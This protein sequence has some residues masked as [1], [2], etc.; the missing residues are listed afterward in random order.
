[1]WKRKAACCT[2]SM[3]CVNEVVGV[4]A[5]R[6][7]LEREQLLVWVSGIVGEL[8]RRLDQLVGSVLA[9]NPVK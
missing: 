8:E 5:R 1:M 9:C 6:A 4:C 2:F 7:Q 3:C